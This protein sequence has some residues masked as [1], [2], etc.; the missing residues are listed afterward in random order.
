MPA[1]AEIDLG[2]LTPEQRAAAVQA[3]AALKTLRAENETLSEEKACLAGENEA[4]A[5]RIRCLEHLVRELRILWQRVRLEENGP[6]S[7]SN[8]AACGCFRKARE[9]GHSTP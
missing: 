2:T 7:I 9:R 6:S 1:L 5:E 8:F 3:L 4:Q